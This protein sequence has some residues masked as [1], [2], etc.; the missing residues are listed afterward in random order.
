VGV[1]GDRGQAGPNG[2]KLMV[3]HVAVQR[4]RHD[5][6]HLA[7]DWRGIAVVGDTTSAIGVQF[8][9]VMTG[10]HNPHEAA[11][12]IAAFGVAGVIGCQVAGYD[13]RPKA[14]AAV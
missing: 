13:V 11:E 10:P 5:L 3:C 4:P 2:R 1:A 6:Q 9:E 8:V 7:V 12:V 14:G